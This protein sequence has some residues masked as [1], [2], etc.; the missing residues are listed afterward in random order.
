MPTESVPSYRKRDDRDQAIVT[1]TDKKTKVRRDYYLGPYD[2]AESRQLYFRLL[3]EWESGVLFMGEKGVLLSGYGKWKLLPESKFADF[4]P[5]QPT[6]P[7]SIGHHKE[8]IIAC[9]TGGETTCNFDYSG[10]LSEAVLL[11]N[12]AYRVGE[13]LQWDPVNLRATNCP[14]AEPYV[15]RSYREGW[16]L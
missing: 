8:W 9:K 14:K 15:R 5:P 12:V 11:G 2:S 6:I 4:K 16:A 3:A 7:E 13:K 1:L 10:A